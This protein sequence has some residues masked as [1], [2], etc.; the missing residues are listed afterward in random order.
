[1]LCHQHLHCPLLH[2]VNCLSWHAS[3]AGVCRG[4]TDGKSPYSRACYIVLFLRC[5][6]EKRMAFACCSSSE[7]LLVVVPSRFYRIRSLLPTAVTHC[8]YK[9]VCRGKCWDLTGCW[10]KCYYSLIPYLRLRDSYWFQGNVCHVWIQH[11]VY[12]AKGCG[13]SL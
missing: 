13:T 8:A 1:M 2:P 5:F 10:S 12:G 11:Q 3:V 4:S 6:S 7:S 9:R